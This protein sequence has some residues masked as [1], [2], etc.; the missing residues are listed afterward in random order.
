[1][2]DY[3]QLC[4]LARLAGGSWNGSWTG[5]SGTGYRPSWIRA[6]TAETWLRRIGHYQ[7][8]LPMLAEPAR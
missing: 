5:R 1:M 8:V 2:A 3:R 6:L 4:W 7:R